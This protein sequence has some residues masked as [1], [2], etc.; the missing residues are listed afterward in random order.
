MCESAGWIQL[1]KPIH[2]EGERM[3]GQK[4]KRKRKRAKNPEA[5]KLGKKRWK[6]MTLAQRAELCA[7]GGKARMKATTKK[8]R[9]A[10]ARKGG[11]ARARKRKETLAKAA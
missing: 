11:L 2:S 5:T 6:K 8:Q 10:I 3:E 1:W 7:K 4:R 9:Q